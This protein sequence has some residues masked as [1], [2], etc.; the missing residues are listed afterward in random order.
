MRPID[1]YHNDKNIIGHQ[2]GR[3]TPLKRISEKGKA[4]Y[5]CRCLCGT[6]LAV[7]GGYLVSKTTRSCGCL[8]TENSRK[9]MQNI[10]DKG[11]NELRKH[12]IEGTNT[13]SFNQ[14]VSKNSKTGI[15]GVSKYKSGQYRAYLT[16]KRKQ[17]HL[18]IF[19]TMEE[20]A[21]ARLEAEKIYY[22]P[23]LEIRGD[24]NEI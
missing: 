8:K 11:H 3:L 14:K 15:K 1:Y 16:I 10:Q 7:K 9:L 18:G 6:E 17:I 23:Y 22:K 24:K 12:A 19:E 2:F 20:A 21:A 4:V 13:I 5:L